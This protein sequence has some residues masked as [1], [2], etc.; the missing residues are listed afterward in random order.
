MKSRIAVKCPWFRDAKQTPGKRNW[1]IIMIKMLL[2]RT[3]SIYA[4]QFL[5]FYI[6][7][8]WVNHLLLLNHPGDN[9]DNN[10]I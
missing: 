1:K 2:V 4:V 10:I 7:L 3:A 9:F 8:N 5:R 6:N